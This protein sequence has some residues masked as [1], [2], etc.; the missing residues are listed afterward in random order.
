MENQE[1]TQSKTPTGEMAILCMTGDIKLSW[2]KEKPEEVAHAKK[3]F[4]DYK[5][6]GYAAFKVKG[7]KGEKG[8][9]MQEFDPAA[10]F[11]ILAPPMVGG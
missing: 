6:K 2:D 3:T 9:I 4:D 11:M 8:E 5:K 10:E 7:P 1:Q